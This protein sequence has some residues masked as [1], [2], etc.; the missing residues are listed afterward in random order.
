LGR[1]PHNTAAIPHRTV[2]NVRSAEFRGH[3]ANRLV[4][5]AE[6]ETGRAADGNERARNGLKNL[7]R[8][9]KAVV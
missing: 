3:L 7:V 9:P 1:D 8:S 6:L 2:Q 5:A 4:G